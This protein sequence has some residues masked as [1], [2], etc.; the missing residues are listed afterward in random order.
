MLTTPIFSPNSESHICK[1]LKFIFTCLSQ[2]SRAHVYQIKL[3]VPLKLVALSD[4][5]WQEMSLSELSKLGTPS[6]LI[7]SLWSPPSLGHKVPLYPS[8]LFPFS[9]PIVITQVQVWVSAEI[10]NTGSSSVNFFPLV[11]P[12]SNISMVPSAGPRLLEDQYFQNLVF[13]SLI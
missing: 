4:L 13:M 7:Y 9:V 3:N 2:S 12:S 5:P 10:Y 1:R 11:S 6:A 8:Y